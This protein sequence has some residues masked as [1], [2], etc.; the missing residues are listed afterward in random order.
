MI[1]RYDQRLQIIGIR[2]E[3]RDDVVLRMIPH[4]ASDAFR[5]LDLGAGMGRF[6][7]KLRERFSRSQIVCVDGS[8]RMLEAAKRR[9]LHEVPNV[10]F[11]CA[12]FGH[13]S[14]VTEVTGT[15]DVVVSTGAIHHVSDPR[16][17][18]L[19]AELYQLLH[20]GGYFVNGDL[21]KSNYPVLTTKYYDDVWA[22]YI[23]QKTRDVLGI[24]RDLGE[25]RRR[26][27][28]ALK[29]EGDQPA[30]VDDQL[31]WLREVGFSVADC[32]WQYYLLT[33]IVGI[34]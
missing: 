14:W 10:V 24:R 12:D 22:H 26:M 3:E 4:G 9:L 17:K 6:T 25:V 20:D 33:V 28:A 2:A 34:K 13:A 16:K 32:V 8:E 30:A 29:Q 18:Q 1:Q 31:R 27:Y 19:F 15:F 21:V 11:I 7:T 5:I 23:Q